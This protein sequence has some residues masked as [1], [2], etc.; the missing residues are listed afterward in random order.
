MIVVV[1]GEERECQ[2]HLGDGKYLVGVTG[3]DF[4]LPW[5]KDQPE[6]APR[7]VNAVAPAAGVPPTYLKESHKRNIK[8]FGK[9]PCWFPGCAE[10][11]EQY[12]QELAALEQAG[13][14]KG[15]EKGV[16]MRKYLDRAEELQNLAPPVP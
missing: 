3:K 2:L 16:L 11:R 7:G 13:G 14:C 5:I 4:L 1:D 10:L 6:A 15:C 9:E 12:S 8:L